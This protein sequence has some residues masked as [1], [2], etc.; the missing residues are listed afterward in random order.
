[1]HALFARA[2]RAQDGYRWFRLVALRG[3]VPDEENRIALFCEGKSTRGV[4]RRLAYLP[5]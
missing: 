5:Q 4:A 1:M 3:R 2:S